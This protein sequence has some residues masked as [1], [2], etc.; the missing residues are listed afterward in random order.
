[1]SKFEPPKL[2]LID[3]WAVIDMLGISES[4]VERLMV[5]DDRFPMPRRIGSRSVRWLEHEVQAY[6]R[7]LTK[8]DYFDQA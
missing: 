4:T 3:R 1:M 5:S 7:S 2:R 6:I 8:V